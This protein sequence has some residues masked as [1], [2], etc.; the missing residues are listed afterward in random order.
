MAASWTE[1]VSRCKSRTSALGRS[2]FLRLGAWR[3]K[4]R[5]ARQALREAQQALQKTR[6]ELARSEARRQELEQQ[7]ER[8]EQQAAEWERRR[9]EPALPLGAA[10]PGQHYGDNL[11]ALSV[12]L[13]RQ[14]GA[15][16]ARR[17]LEI[18]FGG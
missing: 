6:A 2:C 14:I 8:L 13:G 16:R 9:A 11:I 18:F 4:C 17:S 7:L 3:Q 10:P 1:F 5:E 12:N 15:R